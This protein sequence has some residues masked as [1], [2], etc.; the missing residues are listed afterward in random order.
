MRKQE[1]AK[2]ADYWALPLILSLQQTQEEEDKEPE[3]W[4]GPGAVVNL[5][6]S[7]A[8]FRG[9]KQLTSQKALPMAL[10]HQPSTLYQFLHLRR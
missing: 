7:W 9:P 6:H 10:H 3:S 2:R 4:K 1:V 8:C 5:C